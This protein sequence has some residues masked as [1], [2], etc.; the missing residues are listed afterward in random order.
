MSTRDRFLQSDELPR[1]FESVA[2]EPS[3]DVR[4]YVLLSLL[5][6][7]RKSNVL[8]MKWEDI[9]LERGEWRIPGEVS[10]NGETMLVP[11]MP[12][13]IEILRSRKPNSAAVFVFPGEGKQGHM[14][15]ARKGWVRILDRDELT[16]L[17]KRIVEAGGIFEW[18]LMKE[19]GPLDR[20]R[21]YESLAESLNRARAVAEEMNIDTAGARVGNLRIHDMRRTLGSWQLATGASLA[22]IGKS[23]GHKDLGSTEIY[24][25]L[26]IDPVRD[27]MMTGTRAMLAAGGLLPTAEIVPIEQA[28]RKATKRKTA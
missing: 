2:Q 26:N 4:D 21:K 3:I 20:S 1:F 25:R 10:K 17:A 24:A 9:N 18:P 19:K 6:G 15:G 28:K 8:S 16:Q 13:A 22:I 11:L 5:A 23:L 7:A 27:A 14:E 12:E